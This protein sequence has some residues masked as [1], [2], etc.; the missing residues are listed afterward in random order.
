[1]M[2]QQVLE[3]KQKELG[4]D[5]IS[6]LVTINKLGVL[7]QDQGRLQ[8][9]EAMYQQALVGYEKVLGPDNWQTQCSREILSTLWKPQ[10]RLGWEVVSRPF[11]QI[12]LLCFLTSILKKVLRWVGM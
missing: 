2:L 3:V 1:M 9:E 10:R 8:E 6:A 5:H 7:Y 11:M 12:P 4:P